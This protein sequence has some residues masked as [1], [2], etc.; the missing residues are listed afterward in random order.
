[1]ARRLDKYEQILRYVARLVKGSDR[2]LIREALG[3]VD[4]SSEDDET[5]S[6]LSSRKAAAS[7]GYDSDDEELEDESD[8]EVEDDGDESAGGAGTHDL[9]RVDS[10]GSLSHVNE[11]FNRTTV[12]RATGFMG[13][14]SELTWM[15]RLKKEAEHNPEVSEEAMSI[16]GQINFRINSPS[17]QE[18]MHHPISESTYHRDDVSMLILDPVEPYE[19]PPRHTADLLFKCYLDTVHPSF[20]IIGKTTFVGQY[21]NY[22]SKTVQT[23][24]NCNWV[25]ILN[26][27]F[28]I[29]AIYSR[30]IQ[31]DWRGNEHDH[32]IYFTRARL[33][34]FNADSILDHAGLQSVQV[35]G[36][37]AFYLAAI[38][39]INRYSPS[40][41]NFS[42]QGYPVKA[43]RL[44]LEH[45]I[46]V[47]SR[48]GRQV[49]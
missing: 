18:N 26:L 35:T 1:M 31:A 36:L 14:S 22:Y 19:R 3:D 9:A 39:Q 29:G 13:K 8:R 21:R 46:S 30:L 47:A 32:L 48:C 15:Q 12:S 49:L 28:A 40:F 24:V 10:T 11:D 5:L 25:A 27:I 4:M 23:G 44:H 34:A 17:L 38:N 37:M 41:T 43:N 7:S 42:Q 6:L 16:I 20:P 33:L 2:R 45:G